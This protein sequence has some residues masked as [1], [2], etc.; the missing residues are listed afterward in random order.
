MVGE[1][2]EGFLSQ[3]HAQTVGYGYWGHLGVD[4]LVPDGEV[5]VAC[6]LRLN[7]NG[8]ASLP[9]VLGSEYCPAAKAPAAYRKQ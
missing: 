6:Q 5:G 3:V 9:E 1:D 8:L 2:V 7:A 4:L